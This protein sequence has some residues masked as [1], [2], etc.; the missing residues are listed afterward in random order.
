MLEANFCLLGK[1]ALDS[2][3]LIF[4]FL[5][6][7]G[8]ALPS[9]ASLGWDAVRSSECLSAGY[10]NRDRDTGLVG[11]GAAER[12]AVIIALVQQ[13]QGL[14]RLLELRTRGRESILHC[15]LPPEGKCL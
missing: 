14:R 15:C 1:V 13:L 10:R 5:A 11:G 3:P 8:E 6:R 7:G 2:P 4:F 9:P 12:A